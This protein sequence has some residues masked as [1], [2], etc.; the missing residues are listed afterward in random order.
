MAVL[1]FLYNPYIISSPGWANHSDVR[2]TVY[3]RLISPTPIYPSNP[4]FCTILI[5]G[6]SIFIGK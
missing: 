4:T 2:K 3:L 1:P 5:N 6:T